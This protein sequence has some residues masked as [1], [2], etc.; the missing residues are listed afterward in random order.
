ML[1]SSTLLQTSSFLSQEANNINVV[2]V[3]NTRTTP[4][5]APVTRRALRGDRAAHQC[6]GN[7]HEH[8][9][10]P[11]RTMPCVFFDVLFVDVTFGG[12]RCSNTSR[13]IILRSYGANKWSHP[14]LGR[15]NPVRTLN[16]FH[17]NVEPKDVYHSFMTR[18]SVSLDTYKLP[19]LETWVIKR[20]PLQSGFSSHCSI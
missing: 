18:R 8:N 2:K 4:L 5:L 7:T 20:F 12:G 3:I 14:P 1:W 16:M 13:G 17:P 9:A 6:L 10:M 15:Y 19:P 11:L